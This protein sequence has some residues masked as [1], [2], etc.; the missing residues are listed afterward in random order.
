MTELLLMKIL[1]LG[2]QRSRGQGTRG[3]NGRGPR[4]GRVTV[5]A[6]K[7]LDAGVAVTLCGE[8][9]GNSLHHPLPR[10]ERGDRGGAPSVALPEFREVQIA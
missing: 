7:A 1:R 2:S 8:G 3:I 5:Y 4:S 10:G 9:W 6:A